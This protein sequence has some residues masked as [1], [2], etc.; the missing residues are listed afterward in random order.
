MTSK[1]HTEFMSFILDLID[2][3]EARIREGL[4]DEGARAKAVND[5][6]S[7]VP[8]LRDR[9][10]DNETA[11]AQAILL[12][13]NQMYDAN[14]AKWWAE[15]ARMDRAEFAKHAADLMRLLAM[16]RHVAAAAT[17]KA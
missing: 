17:E 5:A 10:S 11:Q 1:R 2:F 3:M 6:A 9:L 14:A 4:D 16:L 12:L 8:L 15:L 13:D 7:V